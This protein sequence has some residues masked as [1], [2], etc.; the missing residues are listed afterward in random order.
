MNKQ[1]PSS[2]PPSATCIATTAVVIDPDPR[3][4]L[5]CHELL[6]EQLASVGQHDLADVRGVLA[7]VTLETLLWQVAHTHQ[8][9]QLTD[10]HAVLVGHVH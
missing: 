8:T 10:V 4:N 9:A 7:V 2:F 6:H 3:C 5:Q 1:L